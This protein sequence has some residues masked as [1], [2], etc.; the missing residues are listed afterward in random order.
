MEPPPLGL[1]VFGL[2]A[3]LHTLFATNLIS[4]TEINMDDCEVVMGEPRF[5]ALRKLVGEE[6][7]KF[8]RYGF[9]YSLWVPTAIC[10]SVVMVT[11]PSDIST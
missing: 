1:A 5:D 9:A 7:V 4:H 10:G 8:G 2:S 11:L 3:V 6:P